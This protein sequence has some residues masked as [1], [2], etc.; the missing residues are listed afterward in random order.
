MFWAVRAWWD[1]RFCRLPAM[2]H[3][4]L[5]LSQFPESQIRQRK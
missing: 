2:Q 3:F 4:Q 5:E 1:I